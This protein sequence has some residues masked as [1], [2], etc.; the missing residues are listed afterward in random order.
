VTVYV[1]GLLQHVYMC[2]FI[3]NC[4]FC[5]EFMIRCRRWVVCS[6]FVIHCRNYVVYSKLAFAIELCVL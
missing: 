4:V 6:E 1:L 3:P 5:S 2:V